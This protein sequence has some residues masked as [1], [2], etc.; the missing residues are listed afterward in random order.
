LK[1]HYQLLGLERGATAE[2]V[3]RAFRREIA[4]YHPDKVHHLGAEFQEIAATRAAELTEAYRVLMDEEER[5][6]YDAALSAPQAE[7]ASRPPAAPEAPATPAPAD[8]PAA[9][10]PRKPVTARTAT[11]QFVKKAALKLFREAVAEVAPTAAPIG[12][13]GFDAAFTLKG[14]RSLFGKGTPD[15][16]ML[17]RV[18]RQVD[19]SAVEE[20]WTLARRV[21]GG[22]AACVLIMGA[23][24]SPAKDLSAAIAEQRRKTRT[25]TLVVVPV[26][27]RD[28]EALFPPETPAPV[29]A[30][31]QR[32]RAGRS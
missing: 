7:R 19:P 28:W 18:V 26:D 8:S 12:A 5:R 14:K 20:A 11:D 23:G 24:L 22:D 6:K 15:V 30:V 25:S 32:L 4:R 10:A 29:R 16:T 17:A 1:T 31:V 21:P 27:V 13:T 3:K 2:E 9:E